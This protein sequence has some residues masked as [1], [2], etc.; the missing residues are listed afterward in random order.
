MIHTQAATCFRPVSG[1]SNRVKLEARVIKSSSGGRKRISVTVNAGNISVK[2]I[3]KKNP[4]DS[5]PI[6]KEVAARSSITFEQDVYTEYVVTLHRKSDNIAFKDLSS[7]QGEPTAFL[8]A[9]GTLSDKEH[10][11]VGLN[12]EGNVSSLLTLADPTPLHTGMKWN[13]VSPKPLREQIN[14]LARMKRERDCGQKPQLSTTEAAT[15]WLTPAFAKL[16]AQ[17]TQ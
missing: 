1:F 11:I 5:Q 4:T 7:L 2:V 10:S 8:D 14:L 13:A 12:A 3:S 17:M 6:V 15:V 16:A 9:N